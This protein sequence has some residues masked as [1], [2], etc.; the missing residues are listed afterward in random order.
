MSDSP[1]SFT[2]Q[3]SWQKSIPTP[4]NADSNLEATLEKFEK[5]LNPKDHSKHPLKREDSDLL[6]NKCN[7]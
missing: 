2:S 5:T 3:I 7:K 6:L 4:S 1:F